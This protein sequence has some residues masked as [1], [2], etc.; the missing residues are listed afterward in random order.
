MM[1]CSLS[2]SFTV[3]KSTRPGARYNPELQLGLDHVRWSASECQFVYYDVN[4]TLPN[5]LLVLY[6]KAVYP[7]SKAVMPW[8][9]HVCHLYST[10]EKV[11][12]AELGQ[13]GQQAVEAGLAQFAGRY[14]EIAKQK[15]LAGRSENYER[16]P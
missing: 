14:G 13:A 3:P 6:R 8:D 9:Y 7:G 1:S 11:I 4:L 5:Y 15:V 12:N 2:A 10:Y 16:L